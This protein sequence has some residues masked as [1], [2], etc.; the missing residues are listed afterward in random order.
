VSVVAT[1]SGR[2]ACF[3]IMSESV[4]V[5]Y[6]ADRVSS[7]KKSFANRLQRIAAFRRMLNA[8]R[9]DVIVSFLPG[10]N[11]ASVV[12]SFGLGIPVIACERTDPLVWPRAHYAN[13]LVRL[14]YRHAAMLTV[15]TEAVAEKI[16]SA[17][18]RLKRLQVV[19]NPIPKEL[20][21]YQHARR[22][23]ARRRLVAVGRLA[24]EK[25]FDLLITVFSLL[26]SQWAEWDLYIYGEG[27]L[28]D[29]LRRQIDNLNMTGR[30]VLA[31]STTKP[32]EEMAQSDA[33]VMTSRIE[34][35][36]NALLE[37]MVLGLPC[38]VFDCPSGPREITRDGRDGVL[39]PLN[40]QEALALALTNVMSSEAF[41]VAL[42]SRA[43]ESTLSRFNLTSVIGSWDR[44]FN[45]V[46]GLQ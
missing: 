3:Y 15:Q 33:F 38:V 13:W 35:F 42:G 14:A 16:P 10:V 29:Q 2:G 25:Q 32:W 43:R 26:A 19:P 40:D 5:V 22:S 44:I 46:R 41:R 45:E 8:E 28:R 30:V 37:A 1:F 11:V 23:G 7:T 18:P 20:Q 9:P 17:F 6:L 12:C 31:G 27:D 24:A 4:R 21:H 34:G 36:P 39:V